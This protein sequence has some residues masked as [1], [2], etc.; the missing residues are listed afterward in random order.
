MVRTSNAGQ[1]VLIERVTSS[2]PDLVM[3]P[4]D[5]GKKRLS[6]ALVLALH[7]WLDKGAEYQQRWA[8]RPIANP[9]PPE[10]PESA[11]GSLEDGS[12]HAAFAASVCHTD[13]N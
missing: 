6:D 10:L 13:R 12:L 4:P 8:F 1:S 7:Q 2:D 9:S 11:Q 5:F 3:P